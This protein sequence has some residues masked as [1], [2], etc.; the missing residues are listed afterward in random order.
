M[1]RLGPG[2]LWAYAAAVSAVVEVETF[3]A[4]GG[5]LTIA[6]AIGRRGVEQASVPPFAFEHAED[7]RFIA[8]LCDGTGDWGEGLA[9]SRVAARQ[10]ALVCAQPGASHAESISRA[11]VAAHARVLAHSSDKT[12]SWSTLAS[13]SSRMTWYT[14]PMG[15]R[16]GI[17]GAA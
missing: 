13:R 7:G 2:G 11:L 4:S 14:T 10:A 8:C 1:G 5:A 12:H 6:T 9:A 17:T 15:G 3:R 16:P